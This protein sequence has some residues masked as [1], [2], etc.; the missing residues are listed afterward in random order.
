LIIVLC[1]VASLIYINPELAR[2]QAFAEKF[3]GRK[4]FVGCTEMQ[5]VAMG[6]IFAVLIFSVFRI[7]RGKWK[8][9]QFW[10]KVGPMPTFLGF[11][12]IPPGIF[13]LMQIDSLGLVLWPLLMLAQGAVIATC[14][15]YMFYLIFQFFC[16]KNS[17][18]LTWLNAYATV[19]GV[20]FFI[21]WLNMAIFFSDI[22]I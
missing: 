5:C 11:L 22:P 16:K 10:E 2:E 14:F 9:M 15:G 1:V 12:I 3:N 18:C 20:F 19:S 4:M 6:M 7:V 13:G 17:A 8:E 21:S